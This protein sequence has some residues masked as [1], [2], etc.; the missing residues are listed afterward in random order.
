MLNQLKRLGTE[1]AIYGISTVLG[2]FLNFLLVPFYTNVLAPGEYGIIAYAYS[3]IAFANVIYS[4]GM[5]SAYF[6]YSSTLE[7]GTQ[8]Q[9]FTTPFISLFT[10]SILFS[11]FITAFARPIG[12]AIAVP[13]SY[14]SILYWSAGILALDGVAIIPFASLRMEHKAKLFASIKFISIFINVLLN[15][16]LL[17]VFRMGVEGVFISGIIASASSLIMLIPTIVKNFSPGINTPLLKALLRFGL[18][19]IPSGLAAMAIQVIDRPILR[20][21]TDDAT[22]GIYQ[23]NYRLGIFMMLIVSMY[24]YAWR[25]FYFSTA[26]DPNAKQIFARVLTYLILFM[27]FIFLVLTFFINDIA[28]L[29]IFGRH[30][31]G[32]G[33]W[34]G[35]GIVPIV[36]LGY[37]FLG[38]STNFS[39]GIF[40]EKKTQY[41]PFITVTGALVNII[42]NFILIPLYGMYGAAWATLVAYAVMALVSYLFVRNIYPVRYEWERILKIAIGT[43]LS[44]ILFYC[45]PVDT[46]SSPIISF[47]W[48]ILLL[49]VFTGAIY[50]F[51]FFKREEAQVIRDI[52]AKTRSLTYG[53]NNDRDAGV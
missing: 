46:V 28:K 17:L 40:I 33:Y 42:V 32:P 6:K 51:K 47:G 16:L 12:D 8:K 1:T 5:E 52:L 23:A 44:V 14:K 21:L 27:A 22:V 25:P 9:N 3:L 2:R 30:I 20:A 18:P 10:T 7:L 13:V 24:E 15:I 53:R 36:L 48:R 38:I 31:I 43:I 29:S 41:T 39:A 35:L 4:Y 11:L 50:F 26:K 34:S 37:L 19:Y 49:A 45:I